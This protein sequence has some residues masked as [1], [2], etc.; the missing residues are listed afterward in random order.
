MTHL[1]NI[2]VL[3][4]FIYKFSDGYKYRKDQSCS[5][6]DEDAANVF[7]SQSAGLFAV[8][9]RAA[10]SPPPLLFHHMQFPLFLQLENSNR[11]FVPVGRA[12]KVI[13]ILV[14]KRLKKTGR[15]IVIL[16]VTTLW[17][18]KGTTGKGHESSILYFEALN[19]SKGDSWL[20]EINSCT[21]WFFF[22]QQGNADLGILQHTSASGGFYD[23]FPRY[24]ISLVRISFF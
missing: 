17:L 10:V 20:V 4:W 8:F 18:A 21:D 12:C 13:W 6:N 1:F 23:S 16:E 5:Q 19:N 7:Y 3:P 15:R 2:I 22:S 9:L 14:T 11:N 24:E